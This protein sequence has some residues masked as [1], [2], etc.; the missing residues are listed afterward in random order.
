[1]KGLR[2]ELARVGIR[3]RR[4]R[5]IEL[6]LADHA[7]CDPDAELG[8]PR[9]IA[10]RFA[11]ELRVPVTRRAVHTGFAAL[12]VLAAGLA[13]ASLGTVP[14]LGGAPGYVIAFA[15]LAIVLGA[16]VAFVA[17]VLALWGIHRG[18]E[19]RVVQRRVLVALAAGVLVIAGEGVDL[20][21]VHSHVWWFAFAA[22]AAVGLARAG[23]ALREAASV[24]PRAAAVRV[25]FTPPE[26]AAVGVA[27]VLAVTVGS[28]VAERSLSEGLNRGAFEAI[29][30]AVCFFALGRRLAIRR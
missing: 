4:A 11:E 17:G 12:A 7:R 24:T 30:F 8:S 20:V 28:A 10:E 16:Q 5:R 26:A 14:D 21:L 22:L 23:L 18:T 27:A 6:E 1:V 9:L 19:L 25:A 3:G 2:E 15:G 29:A 13:L